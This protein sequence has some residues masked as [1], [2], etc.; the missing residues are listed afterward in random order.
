MG[1]MRGL[2]IAA[3][4]L[5]AAGGA[6]FA[7]PDC[8]MVQVGELPVSLDG[9][10]ITVAVQVN[11]KPARM[12]VDTGSE[13]T[14]IFRES[15]KVLGLK[16]HR[17]E[18]IEFYGVGGETD[19]GVVRVKELRV[20][21]FVATDQDLIVTGEHALGDTVGLLGSAF[22]M[23]ADVEFDLA[24]KTIRF[25]E[26]KNCVGDQVVYWGKAYSVAPMI[27]LPTRD[28]HVTVALNG[29]SIVA[30]MD[31]GSSNTIVTV[32]RAAKAGVTP[33]SSGVIAAGASLGM[34]AKAEQ[35][36]EAVF[37]TF[38]FG[39]ETIKNA[40]LQIADLFEADKEVELGSHIAASVI[41]NAPQ[42][43]L[44]ADFLKAHRVYIARGQKKVY[45]SY[46][47]GP[48]FEAPQRPPATSTAAPPPAVPASR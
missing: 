2:A 26:P 15:A 18:N 31:S 22:L 12:I 32:G 35:T 19:G 8:Q 42:M 41:D 13:T 45:I 47:G 30:E 39:D 25:F 21:Q 43:L 29:A 3:A 33:R 27:A 48:V 24:D 1:R 28:V 7:A 40:R 34:G 20:A 14:L 46:T 36:F 6:A 38:S 37:P 17:V 16:P 10:M 4:A 23:Q 9:G 44:G 5:A 11:G